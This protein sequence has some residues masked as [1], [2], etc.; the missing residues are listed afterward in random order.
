MENIPNV[1]E[2]VTLSSLMR[3]IEQV[4]NEMNEDPQMRSHFIHG[5]MSHRVREGNFSDFLTAETQL[6][7]RAV[8]HVLSEFQESLRARQCT[9]EEYGLLKKLEKLT[10]FS[11]KKAEF[12]ALYI[13]AKDDPKLSDLALVMEQDS[14]FLSERYRKYMEEYTAPSTKE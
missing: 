11:N 12:F 3:K 2:A 6:E 5:G 4:R 14:P 10:S 7:A 1:A 8:A 13:D 9:K